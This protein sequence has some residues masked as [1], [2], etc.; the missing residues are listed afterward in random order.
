MRH[1]VDCGGGVW[2]R[3]LIL[4]AFQILETRGNGPTY[5]AGGRNFV[6]STLHWGPTSGLDR[7]WKTSGSITYSRTDFSNDFHTFGLEW[8]PDYMLTCESR[9]SWICVYILGNELNGLY[10]LFCP[11]QMWILV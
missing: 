2:A 3:L 4:V 6:Q 9:E 5:P 1:H 7:F 10:V 8:T 11:P